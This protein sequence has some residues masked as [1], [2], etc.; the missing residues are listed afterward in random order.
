MKQ[1]WQWFTKM[2]WKLHVKKQNTFC[3]QNEINDSEKN[4]KKNMCI[5][6]TIKAYWLVGKNDL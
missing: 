6:D 2:V 5:Y 1:T 4:N 3:F